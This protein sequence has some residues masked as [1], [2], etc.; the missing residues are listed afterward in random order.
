MKDRRTVKYVGTDL[1][2]AFEHLLK[3]TPMAAAL[4]KDCTPLSW[5][6]DHYRSGKRRYVVKG[7]HADGQVVEMKVTA[8]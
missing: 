8:G 6:E 7:Q 3:T 5:R 1:T 2:S 4:F